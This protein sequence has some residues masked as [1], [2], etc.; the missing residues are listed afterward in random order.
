MYQKTID[1]LKKT[2]TAAK[3]ITEL[4]KISAATE[5]PQ[6]KRLVDALLDR[7]QN[8]H[9]TAKKGNSTP[10]ALYPL[11]DNAIRGLIG[12]C[13]SYIQAGKPEWQVMAER[14]GWTPP[15]SA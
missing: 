3:H 8:A 10:K 9:A 12:Y 11:P 7:L 1:S 14:H 5:D 4:G 2:Q 13:E 6:L 15:A